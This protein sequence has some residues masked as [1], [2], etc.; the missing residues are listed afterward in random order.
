MY[1]SVKVCNRKFEIRHGFRQ[2]TIDISVNSNQILMKFW[3]LLSNETKNVLP[4]QV[5]IIFKIGY[6]RV[7]QNLNH[8]VEY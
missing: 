7:T 1:I 8:F 3:N 6:F 4:L 2:T 5:L